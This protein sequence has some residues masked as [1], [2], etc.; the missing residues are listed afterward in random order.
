MMTEV[1]EELQSEEWDKDKS[2]IE[3]KKTAATWHPVGLEY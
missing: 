3:Q 2:S 1:S